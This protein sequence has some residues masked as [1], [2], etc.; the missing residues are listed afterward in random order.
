ML[1][2]HVNPRN[3]TPVQSDCNYQNTSRRRRKKRGYFIFSFN[4]AKKTPCRQSIEHQTSY[5]RLT[6]LT[7]AMI[8]A[9]W[10]DLW[11]IDGQIQQLPSQAPIFLNS[12]ADFTVW[13]LPNSESP[14]STDVFVT[15]LVFKTPE[16]SYFDSPDR[17]RKYLLVRRVGGIRKRLAWEFG[18]RCRWR[19]NGG[20]IRAEMKRFR[21]RRLVE[22][23]GGSGGGITAAIGSMDRIPDFHCVAGKVKWS[24]VILYNRIFRIRIRTVFGYFINIWIRIWNLPLRL[25]CN[26][27]WFVSSLLCS[28]F[29]ARVGEIENMNR[30]QRRVCLYPTLLL[31][32][33]LVLFFYRNPPPSIQDVDHSKVNVKSIYDITVKVK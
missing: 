1:L 9:A 27:V 26:I 19:R 15:G 6:P 3:Y 12:N 23:G 16:F 18:T 22:F 11:V 33:S 24:R 30:F 31:G 5:L 28:L 14:L 25:N 21:R 4:S 7:S 29:E 10:Y 32:F 13:I 8:S 20:V 17:T 2:N